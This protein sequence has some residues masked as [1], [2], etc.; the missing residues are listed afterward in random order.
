MKGV[1]I[2]GKRPCLS[3][4]STPSGEN[5]AQTSYSCTGWDR[6]PDTRKKPSRTWARIEE[7]ILDYSTTNQATLISTQNGICGTPI[8]IA[9]HTSTCG[10]AQQ[11]A[12]H[13]GS[14]R[15]KVPNM[16]QAAPHT[17]QTS[18][19]THPARL[20]SPRPAPPRASDVLP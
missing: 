5:R 19:L 8:L 9:A 1:Q 14:K 18:K 7:C 11:N 10:A 12:P 6:E 16:R 3:C 20:S 13:L 15:F 2:G 4:R 17:S